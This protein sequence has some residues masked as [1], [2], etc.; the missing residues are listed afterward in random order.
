MRL[1]NPAFTVALKNPVKVDVRRR[2]RR[3]FLSIFPFFFFF[4]QRKFSASLSSTNQCQDNPRQDVYSFKQVRRRSTLTASPFLTNL[5]HPSQRSSTIRHG[6]SISKAS[7]RKSESKSAGTLSTCTLLPF[8]RRFCYGTS[9]TLVLAT[10]LTSYSVKH[11]SFNNTSWLD[12]YCI[13]K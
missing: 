7:D 3:Y 12:F 9:P 10:Y 5:F 6:C 8:H 13:N 11:F 4:R 2:G 1:D